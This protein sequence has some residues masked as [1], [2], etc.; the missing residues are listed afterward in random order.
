M[1]KKHTILLDLDSTL[2][3]FLATFL[4]EVKKK[5]NKDI[6]VQD[7]ISY[8]YIHDLVGADCRDIYLQNDFYKKVQPFLGAEDFVERLCEKYNVKIVTVSNTKDNQSSKTSFINKHFPSVSEII[9]TEDKWKVEGDIL[10]DDSFEQVNNFIDLSKRY[11]ILFN[12]EGQ[13]KYND[14]FKNSGLFR[15]YTKYSQIENF[16]D[17][18]FKV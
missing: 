7:I 14:F 1:N 17:Y 4:E 16:L 12:F 2:C 13:Y 5:Y 15:R 18:T 8:H 9:F 11:S 3:D 10:I 6:K